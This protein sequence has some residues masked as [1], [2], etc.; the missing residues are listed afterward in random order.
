MAE[1]PRVGEREVVA[2]DQPSDGRATERPAIAVA[3]AEGEQTDDDRAEGEATARSREPE[4]EAT[5]ATAV[6]DDGP[7]DIDAPDA[8]SAETPGG[9][10][11]LDPPASVAD[12]PA[13][14]GMG[15]AAG[16]GATLEPL[17]RLDTI[18]PPFGVAPVV[19]PVVRPVRWRRLR[20]LLSVLASIIVGVPTVIVVIGLAVMLL[21]NPIWVASEQDRAESGLETGYGPVE[22]RLATDSIL[23]DL[24]FGPPNFAVTIG[25]QPVL[26][27]RE[28]SHL[29]DVRNVFIEFA[30]VALTSLLILVLARILSRRN[31]IAFWSRV[32]RASQ[33]LAY[34]VVFVGLVAV[35]AFA[36][37]FE[38]FHGLLFPAGS[39]DFDPSR[40][41]LVQLF[42]ERF[43][44]DTALAL[45]AAIFAI[46]LLSVWW[47]GRRIRNLSE[48][49]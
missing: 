18:P 13:V 33:V 39:F 37:L 22:L 8:A 17:P 43:W 24:V 32:R 27:E 29:R 45:A 25:G 10:W 3:A 31:P 47:A 15:M 12:E 28:R 42:P 21:L 46:S 2:G 38:L 40:D 19:E 20:R 49:R 9:P 14:A 16:A 7:A 5:T 26:A 30:A 36:P 4:V 35:I 48:P 41:R 44:S 6:T 11:V 34:A 1:D 23:S